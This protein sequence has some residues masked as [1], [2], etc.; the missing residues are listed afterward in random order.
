M[1]LWLRY[2]Q[3]IEGL[4]ER[5]GALVGWLTLAM[6]LIG[7]YNTVGRFL[8]RAAGHNLASNALIELQWYL[9]S[10][11]FLLGAAYTLRRDAHVRVDVIYSQVSRKVRLWI[12]LVGTVIFLLPFSIFLFWVSLPSV[13]SSWKVWEGSP[14]PGGLPRYP[15]KSMILVACVLLILQ[16]IAMLGR[17]IAELR[18]VDD[19]PD[20]APRDLGGH[21]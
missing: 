6:V 9:F 3:A 4:N 11:V 13:I 21:L 19:R 14:D 18:G 2:A 20:E 8:S 16:G 10:L 12:D 1:R 7:S 15:I 17:Q 5:L